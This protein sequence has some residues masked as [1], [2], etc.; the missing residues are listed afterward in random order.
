M[1]NPVME[2]RVTPEEYDKCEAL[3]VSEFGFLGACGK[4]TTTAYLDGTPIDTSS[5]VWRQHT[6]TFEKENVSNGIRKHYGDPEKLTI[7]EYLLYSGL[8]QGLMYQYALESMRLR[9]NCHGALFW[10]FEDCWGEIG[11]TIIDYYL[12]RKPAFYFVK[13]AFDPIRLIIRARGEKL[14]VITANDSSEDVK[15]NLQCGYVPLDGAKSQLKTYVVKAPALQRTKCCVFPKG[16][17]DPHAGLWGARCTNDSCVK[18]AVFRAVDY[19]MLKTQDPKLI[20]TIKPGKGNS[21][22]VKIST[23][24][25]AHA[26]CFKLPAGAVPEDDY[27]DLLPGE[28]RTIRIVSDKPFDA[29]EVKVTCVNESI[30]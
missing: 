22:L 9:A 13:R 21:C 5:E 23:R 6:N 12:R 30:F 26:V 24:D 11:W 28:T 1:M 18:P 16:R 3:F 15:L 4:E 25:W 8:V 7:D 27:F 29:G 20:Y 14:C 10:M 17:H 2:K 19:R